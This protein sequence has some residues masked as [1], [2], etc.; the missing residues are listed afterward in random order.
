MKTFVKEGRLG[1]MGGGWVMNDESLNEYKD[2]VL[3]METGLKWLK[4]NLNYVPR[5]AWQI[6][7]FG[8]SPVTP[9]LYHSLGFESIVLNRIGTTHNALLKSKGATEFVWTGAETSLGRDELFAH[10]LVGN[11]YN[12]PFELKLVSKD[13]ASWFTPK[14]DC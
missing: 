10:V 6:D 1:I 5:V 9:A 7:P 13:Y 8:N 14:V 11:R 2:M 3:N 4:K 12:L